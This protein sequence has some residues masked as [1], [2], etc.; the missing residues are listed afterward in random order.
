MESSVTSRVGP[1]T[2]RAL[3]TLVSQHLVVSI[4]GYSIDTK[5]S[6]FPPF[7][8][9]L[10]HVNL[11]AFTAPPLQ[12]IFFTL[13][14]GKINHSKISPAATAC[15]MVYRGCNLKIAAFL[16]R[17]LRSMASFIYDGHVV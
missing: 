5:K 17:C 16:R 15:L 7:L 2:A 4:Q 6:V 10:L 9:C 8:C 12:S 13:A 1:S 14:F 3:A 11:S